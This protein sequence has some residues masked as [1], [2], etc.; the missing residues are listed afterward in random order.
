MTIFTRYTYI[1]VHPV[2]IDHLR[3]TDLSDSEENM[4]SSGGYC[5]FRSER[6]ICFVFRR[7]Q[8]VTLAIKP[9]LLLFI[10][11]SCVFPLGCC[12]IYMDLSI[13]F[14]YFIST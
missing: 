1:L 6:E 9:H 14:R 12:L 5:F 4:F 10:Q 2:A 13:D 3:I 11:M 7:F 8:V